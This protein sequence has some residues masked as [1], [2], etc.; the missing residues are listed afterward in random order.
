[1]PSPLFWPRCWSRRHAA[2]AGRVAWLQRDAGHWPRTPARATHHRPTSRWV[3][4]RRVAIWYVSSSPPGS[5]A[6][7]LPPSPLRT[8]RASCPACRSSLAN[9]LW[10][11]RFHDGPS[12]AVDLGMAGWME[13]DAVFDMVRAA[14]CAPHQMMTMP[15]GQLREALL[16]D[17]TAAVLLLPQTKQRSSPLQIVSHMHAQPGC[18]VRFPL[19]IIRLGLAL[20]FGVP[21]HRHTR[22][23]EQAHVLL[24]P[25]GTRD[26]PKE[27]PVVPVCG[28]NVFVPN[29]RASLARVSPPRP[30]P[31]QGKDLMVSLRQG[32]LAGPML[33][34]LRPAPNHR[35]QL[36]DQV[37]RDGWL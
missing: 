26:V 11:T 24:C 30:L 15:A 5:R 31:Q 19:W 37:A 10:R 9:A 21:T 36:H 33:V 34:R 23:A 17:R 2:R 12:L 8:T 20:D 13:Q 16:T 29:P 27:H 3:G 25:L 22:G 28:S 14:V 7:L 4:T 32:P 6:R 18:K 35:S 1:M